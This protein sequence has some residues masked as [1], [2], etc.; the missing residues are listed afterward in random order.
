MYIPAVKIGDDIVSACLAEAFY[1]H[2]GG[3]NRTAVFVT[4][5]SVLGVHRF[6]GFLRPKTVQ[7]IRKHKKRYIVK[8][9]VFRLFLTPYHLS[10]GRSFASPL[11]RQRS[12]LRIT[13]CL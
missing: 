3:R 2:I 5:F 8:F 10:K 12:K 6:H 4:V 9:I 1:N 13:F 11:L 7:H